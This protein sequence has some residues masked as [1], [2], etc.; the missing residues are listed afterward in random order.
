MTSSWQRWFPG[1]T[2]VGRR[3][4]WRLIRFAE[5]DAEGKPVGRPIEA[6]APGGHPRFFLTEAAA[7]SAARWLNAEDGL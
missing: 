4:G 3:Q 1:P 5:V 2:A 7:E 6:I